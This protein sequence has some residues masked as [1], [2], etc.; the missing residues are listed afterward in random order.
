MVLVEFVAATIFAWLIE[1]TIWF[2]LVAV[3]VR[4]FGV[5]LP[6]FW[7]SKP[8]VAVRGVGR[9]GYVLVEGVLKY[10]LGSWLLLSTANYFSNR[11]EEYPLFGEMKLGVF[12]FSMA[13]FMLMGFLVGLADWARGHRQHSPSPD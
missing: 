7:W 6:I 2:A 1:A 11:F 12:F 13:G 3:I 8:E 9:W 4:P 10:G 5:K